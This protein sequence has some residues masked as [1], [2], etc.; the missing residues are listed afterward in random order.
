M[1]IRYVTDKTTTMYKNPTGR[2]RHGI[3]IFGDELRTTGSAANGRVPIEFRGRPGFVNALELGTEAP[4]EFYSIDVGQGDATFIVTPGRKKILIDGG[5][6]RRALGFLIWRYRLD[7]PQNSVDIDLMVLTHAD[8][9]HLKGLTPIIQHPQIHVRTIVHNGIAIFSS[10]HGT[11]LGDLDATGE[12]LLTRHDSLADLSSMAGL[13]SDLDAWR[14]AVAAEGAAYR[15]VDSNTGGIDVNDPVIN[16]EVLGP[17][18]EADGSYRWFNDPAHTINGHSVV[19]RLIYDWVSILLPGDLNIEGS[20]HLL[21]DPVLASRMGAHIL[22]CP[23]HGSREFHHLF[24]EAV[25]PQ[26]STISSGDTPDHGHP[27]ASFIGAV[28]RASRSPRPLVFS[29]EL[30]ATFVG[31]GATADPS[32]GTAIDG[33]DFTKATGNE[34]ARKRFKLLLPGIINIRTDGRELYA[35]RR[36]NASYQWEAYEPAEPAPRPSVFGDG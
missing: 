6:G 28:G 7:I 30:A 12:F 5:L 25:R 27:R 20:K 16:I 17:R 15:S 14:Q 29:T 35:A 13:S 36:V 11:K 31:D 4:L 22:K 18:R 10:G 8:G 34:T 23:H 26:I 1:A 2:G 21:A 19:L 33:L 32:E 9:D 3:L 24:L